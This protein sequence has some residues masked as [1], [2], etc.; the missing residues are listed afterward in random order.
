MKRLLIIL[1]LILPLSSFPFAEETKQEEHL[2]F[3]GINLGMTSQKLDDYILKSKE[4]KYRYASSAKGKDVILITRIVGTLTY[5]KDDP[6]K[7]G[8]DGTGECYFVE[9]IFI[10]FL[11]D[12][13]I[14]ISLPCEEYS[15][16]YI[17]TSIK[18][19]G[20]FALKGLIKSMDSLQKL[21]HR[22][23]N[24][25]Y[26]LSRAITMYSCMNGKEARNEYYLLPANHSL[27]I[28]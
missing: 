23:N 1:L 27:N 2:G 5:T 26:S 25:I 9:H 4:L 6:L 14:Q 19:W 13:I 16:D 7:I 8:C 20:E 22:L 18:E 15:A 17:D 3:K 21:T 28:I 11:N 10:K 24:Y 12:K